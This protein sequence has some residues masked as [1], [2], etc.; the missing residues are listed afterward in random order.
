MD[1]VTGTIVPLKLDTGAKANLISI[2]DI[3]EMK[4]KK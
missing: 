4:I 3:K 2:S 1:C